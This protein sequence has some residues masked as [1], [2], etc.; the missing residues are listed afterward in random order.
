M[1]LL[2]V[3]LLAAVMV[4]PSQTA[5]QT[6][7]PAT[8]T[9]QPANPP[10]ATPQGGVAGSVAAPLCAPVQ[11]SGPDGVGVRSAPCGTGPGARSTGGN[12]AREIVAGF[13]VQASPAAAVD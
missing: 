6:Q 7:Q 9:T 12:L 8:G 1:G 4:S 10:A 3:A 11:Q 5:T 13:A 2:S